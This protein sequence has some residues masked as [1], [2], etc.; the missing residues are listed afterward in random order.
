[1]HAVNN[2]GF[3]LLELM[4]AVVIVGILAAIA[5]PTYGNYVLRSNR[6]IAKTVLME[7]SAKQESFYNDRKRYAATLSGLG[8]AGDT[9]YMTRDG[10]TNA[11]STTDA[12]YKLQLLGY[13]AGTLANCSGTGTPAATSF[14][15]Q[16]EPINRQ[17]KDSE[18]AKICLA[19]DGTRGKS[20]TS[21]DCW[22]R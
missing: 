10:K 14:I 3:S 15:V 16:A 4:I 13:T 21:A 2:R 1:M 19:Q 5:L 8:Y 6:T 12:V 17:L 18:C 7:I 9:L 20:G 11:A 22:K